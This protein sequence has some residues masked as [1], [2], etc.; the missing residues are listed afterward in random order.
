[1]NAERFDLNE[2]KPGAYDPLL[3]INRQLHNSSLSKREILLIYLRA[4]QMNGCAFCV[5]THTQEALDDG[6]KQ[7][8]LH[9]LPYWRDSPF[10]S[11]EEEVILEVT[12]EITDIQNQGLPEKT[13]T[14][15]IETFDTG[16]VGDIILAAVC[17]NAWNRIG[18]ATLLIPQPAEN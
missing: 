3:Q 4:S 5:Q 12:E 16:K 6:E 8:R 17:I 11:L 1:M 9:A 10:F 14:K 2:L 13:Y 7:Y 15:A 18:R